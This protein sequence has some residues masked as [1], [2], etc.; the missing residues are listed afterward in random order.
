EA[1][2]RIGGRIL[3]VQS[4]NRFVPFELGAEFI[5]GENEVMWDFIRKG[6]FGVRKVTDEHWVFPPLSKGNEFWSQ[7][8]QCIAGID[9][10]TPDKSFDQYLRGHQP[11][12]ASEWMIRMFVEGFDAADTSKISSHSLK[13]ASEDE[14]QEKTAWLERGYAA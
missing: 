7:L 8:Q 11:P 14:T 10:N 4:G 3:T 12:C 1:R 5:H 6:R 9:F 13:K 2:H